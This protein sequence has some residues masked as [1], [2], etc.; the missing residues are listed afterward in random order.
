M[1]GERWDGSETSDGGP[2]SLVSLQL[3]APRTLVLEVRIGQAPLRAIEFAQVKDLQVEGD[4]EWA[5][6]AVLGWEVLDTS[7]VVARRPRD[8]GLVVYVLELPQA[9]V[10]FASSVGAWRSKA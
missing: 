9:L 7:M 3:V 10:C 4:L 1:G 8:D 5:G 6:L 2:A